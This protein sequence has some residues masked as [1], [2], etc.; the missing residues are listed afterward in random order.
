MDVGNHLFVAV[1]RA[2]VPGD[3]VELAGTQPAW[4]GWEAP[5]QPRPRELTGQRILGPHSAEALRQR[6]GQLL[7]EVEP[8]APD[9]GGD[10]AH[11]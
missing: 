10:Q 3:P 4:T 1:V 2:R 8:I 9:P 7:P 11:F 5:F 6:I